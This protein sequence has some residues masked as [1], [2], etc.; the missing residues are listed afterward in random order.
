[1]GT[2]HG[3]TFK[4]SVGKSVDFL[5]CTVDLKPNGCLTTKLYTKPTDASRYLN[6]RSDHSPHTF[7]SIPYSQF[8]RAALLCSDVEEKFECM[9]YI[10]EKLINS[11]F[12]QEEIEKAKKKALKLKRTEMLCPKRKPLALMMNPKH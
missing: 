2:D 8:R 9:Q 4:G 3:I 5:D 10:S 12:K 11:D 1:M 6:R 7:G